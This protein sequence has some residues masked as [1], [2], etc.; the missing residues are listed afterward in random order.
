MGVFSTEES[1]GIERVTQGLKESDKPNEKEGTQ[2]LA[3]Q[4]EQEA[5]TTLG[6]EELRAVVLYKRSE[7]WGMHQARARAVAETQLLPEMQP[8]Q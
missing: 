2:K 4:K 7:P 1:H 6:W 8:W 5:T 3:T